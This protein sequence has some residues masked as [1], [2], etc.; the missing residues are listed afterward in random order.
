MIRYVGIF[1]VV[2]VVKLG[3]FTVFGRPGGDGRVP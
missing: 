2:G 3:S 1:N